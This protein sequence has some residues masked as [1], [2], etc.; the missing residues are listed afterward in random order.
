MPARLLIQAKK[1]YQKLSNISSTYLIRT[2]WFLCTQHGLQHGLQGFQ[3]H[4]TKRVKNFIVLREINGCQYIKFWKN[5]TKTRQ[6]GPRPK[7][8]RTIT[9]MFAVGG[10]RCPVRLFKM[11]L[12]KQPDDLRNSGR[13]YLTTKQTVLQTDE[14]W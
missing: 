11:H 14:I 4:T 6:G 1:N 12:S 9:K 7:Q 10:E 5:S 3:E 2:M 8:R 13:S